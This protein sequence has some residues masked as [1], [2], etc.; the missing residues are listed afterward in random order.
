MARKEETLAV[1]K[2][3]IAS[4]ECLYAELEDKSGDKRIIQANQSKRGEKS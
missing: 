2:A 3:K 1:T 4:F